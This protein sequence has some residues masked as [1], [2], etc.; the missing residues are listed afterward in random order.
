MDAST[1]KASNQCSTIPAGVMH[2]LMGGAVAGA[3]VLS[4]LSG[5]R[6]ARERTSRGLPPFI[7]CCTGAAVTDGAQETL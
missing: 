7:D 4:E 6:F 5:Q 3:S 2:I 1:P